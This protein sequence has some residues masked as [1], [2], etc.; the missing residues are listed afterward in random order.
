M[1]AA[2]AASPDT[3]GLKARGNRAV[4]WRISAEPVDYDEAVEAM[5][6]RV[7]AIVAGTA[8]ELVWLLEHPPLYTAGTSADPRD[9]LE[10]DR[11]PVYRTGRGGQF[12][13]HGPGQRVIYTMLDLNRRSRDV[14]A[15]VA[16]LEEWVIDALAALGI[17]AR[18]RPGC[19]GVWVERPDKGP[20]RMDK[21]AA[22]G[23]RLS[24]WVSYHGVA[25][26]LDP[27]LSEYRGIVPCGLADQSMTS[28]A[29]LGHEVSMPELDR[30]LSETFE[31][32][33]G[34]IEAP[35]YA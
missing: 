6:A 2:P 35:E 30:A 4:E 13:Y 34:A 24:R 27:D 25:V 17:A 8:P 31:P 32:L 22:I 18:R 21:I 20:D 9:L 15:F 12:T 33:F 29:A 1:P 23:V 10:P 26:N 14:R 11:L 3:S 5:Q 16:A 28:I 19:I 7:A